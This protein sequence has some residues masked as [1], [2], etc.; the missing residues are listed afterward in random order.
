MFL[1]SDTIY[2]KI[3]FVIFYF[4]KTYKQTHI[5]YSRIVIGNNMLQQR[6]KGWGH[7]LDSGDDTL[8]PEQPFLVRFGVY[9]ARFSRMKKDPRTRN[10]DPIVDITDVFNSNDPYEGRIIESKHGVFAH[11]ANSI[12]ERVINLREELGQ[13]SVKVISLP[14]NPTSLY[15]LVG[16]DEEPNLPVQDM[17]VEEAHSVLVG[18]RV[19]YAKFIEVSKSESKDPCLRVFK[20]DKIKRF[21]FLRGAGDLANY[22]LT[23]DPIYRSRRSAEYTITEEILRGRQGSA[24]EPLTLGDYLI[25]RLVGENP[26]KTTLFFEPLVNFMEDDDAFTPDGKRKLLTR[27][28]GYSTGDF[29]Y[30][31]PILG[32]ERPNR[33]PTL[34]RG[35]GYVPRPEEEPQNFFYKPVVIIGAAEEQGKYVAEARII[36]NKGVILA[37]RVS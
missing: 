32:T 37:E 15:I 5:S 21:G 28:E 17:A 4:V 13:F 25:V 18:D 7:L 16:T 34:I 6:D 36:C 8:V 12:R 9:P 35:T 27:V 23:G 19:F 24:Q 33:D 11:L 30:D 20:R 3:I 10:Y 14:R 22:D 26:D 31:I 29:I 1:V 2:K